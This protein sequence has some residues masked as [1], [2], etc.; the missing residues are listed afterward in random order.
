M[1]AALK[2]LS[3]DSWAFVCRLGVEAEAFLVPETTCFISHFCR[4]SRT[5]VPVGCNAW[6]SC[7][8]FLSHIGVFF[9][10]AVYICKSI[11]LLY[12]YG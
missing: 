10:Y 7:Q 1:L 5:L 8:A 11:K 9:G 12:Y 2:E 3:P 6:T 4:L